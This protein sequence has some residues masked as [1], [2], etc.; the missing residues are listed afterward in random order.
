LEMKPDPSSSLWVHPT[1][2]S[3]NMSLQRCSPTPQRCLPARTD[4]PFKSAH[5]SPCTLCR[6]QAQRKSS[7]TDRSET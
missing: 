6:L 5:C 4:R 1:I 7:C 3:L 2:T